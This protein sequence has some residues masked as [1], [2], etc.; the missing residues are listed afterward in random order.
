M[1]TLENKIRDRI[2]KHEQ[3]KNSFRITDGALHSWYFK[4]NKRFTYNEMTAQVNSNLD[5]TIKN[6]IKL[7]RQSHEN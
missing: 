6:I 2:K 4:D 7:L 3:F 1:K 5:K